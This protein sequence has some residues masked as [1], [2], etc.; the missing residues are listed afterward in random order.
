MHIAILPIIGLL[1]IVAILW[2]AINQMTL[3]PPVKMVVIVIGCVL[4]ILIVAQIFG[5]FNGAGITLSGLHLPG[6]PL[7]A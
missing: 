4:L 6:Y 5:V 2:Y 3:P 7:L 1:L